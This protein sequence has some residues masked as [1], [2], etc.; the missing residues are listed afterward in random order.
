MPTRMEPTVAAPTAAH[1]VPRA[2][3]LE[4]TWRP[5]P[6]ATLV[7]LNSLAADDRAWHPFGAEGAAVVTYPGHGGRTRRAGWT[8]QELAD[9]VVAEVAG[10]L[11]VVGVGLGGL[12]GLHLLVRHPDRVRSA[13]LAC[14]GDAGADPVRAPAIERAATARATAALDSGMGAVEQDTL[15]RWFTPLAVRT[16]HPGVQYARNL[17]RDTDSAAWA[18]SWLSLARSP[19]PTEQQV[20]AIDCPVTVVAGMHDRSTGFDGRQ[21]LHRLIPRSRLEIVGGPH[22]MHLERPENLR[23]SVVRHLAWRQAGERVEHAIA[24]PG[25]PDA[26]TGLRGF[27]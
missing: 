11:D 19:L 16:D 3:V 14:G 5:A 9:E 27:G 10:P 25:R 13:V 24:S 7:L 26:A 17:L 18:D 23:A 21:R 20:A 2:L 6:G 4:P 12:V 1:T 22:L 8:H 15:R